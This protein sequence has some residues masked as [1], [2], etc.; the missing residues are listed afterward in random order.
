MLVIKEDKGMDEAKQMDY[1]RQIREDLKLIRTMK[2]YADGGADVEL[3]KARGGGY[4][5]LCVSKK[6]IAED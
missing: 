2:R 3:R 5:I 1:P 6:I 4:K